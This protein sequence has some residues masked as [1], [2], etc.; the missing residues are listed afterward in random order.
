MERHRYIYYYNVFNNLV[1]NLSS[2]RDN[3]VPE[4]QISKLMNKFQFLMVVASTKSDRFNKIVSDVIGMGFSPKASSFQNAI[5]A[6]RRESIWQRKHQI[7]ESLGFSEKEILSMFKKEPRAL[8]LS[9]RKI[10]KTV[11]FFLKKVHW[12]SSQFS[13]R[14]YVLVYSLEKRIIPRCSVLQVLV[15]RN[16][17]KKS[18]TV[19]SLLTMAEKDFFS[20]FVH[21]NAEKI[22]ELLDAYQG[23]LEF[24]EY[25]FDSGK[26]KESL[27]S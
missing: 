21:E 15:S 6:L 10:R 20:T 14:P 5:I 12:S 4:S 11:E 1:P 27:A 13:A 26:T 23:K 8:S 18:M 3:G 22:P 24:D 2:L 7:Y 17:I 25:N 16:W 19:L 9:E